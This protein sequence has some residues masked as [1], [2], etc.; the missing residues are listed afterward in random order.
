MPAKI[1]KINLPQ[2]KKNKFFVNRRQI[3][4]EQSTPLNRKHSSKTSPKIGGKGFI[5]QQRIPKEVSDLFYTIAKKSQGRY[6]LISSKETDALR[7]KIRKKM[8]L[9]KGTSV[10]F[11]RFEKNY[12]IKVSKFGGTIDPKQNIIYLITDKTIISELNPHLKAFNRKK[13]DL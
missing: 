4:E 11:C 6:E 8:N 7:E 13:T 12:Y 2:I 1:N 3:S 5:K 9:R 10:E